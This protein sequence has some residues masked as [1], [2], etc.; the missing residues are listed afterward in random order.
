M[1]WIVSFQVSSVVPFANPASAKD[2][3][4]FAGD[5]GLARS[6]RKAVF[7]LPWMIAN[8]AAFVFCLWSIRSSVDSSSSSSERPKPQ[9]RRQSRRWAGYLVSVLEYL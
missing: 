2:S 9:E 7:G 8:S 5:A 3:T 1:S 6:A 4:L